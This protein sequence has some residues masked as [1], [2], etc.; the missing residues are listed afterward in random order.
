MKVG[1]RGILVVV[2]KDGNVSSV[3]PHIGTAFS[4]AMTIDTTFLCI[5]LEALVH[6]V[7]NTHKVH[8]ITSRLGPAL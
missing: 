3:K 2:V 6:Q 1:H 8:Q 4:S 5:C 7:R